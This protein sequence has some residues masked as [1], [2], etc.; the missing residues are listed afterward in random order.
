ML[1]SQELNLVA[2]NKCT[3]DDPYNKSIIY[4]NFILMIFLKILVLDM[5]NLELLK[6]SPYKNK[7][8]LAIPW[9]LL[10]LSPNF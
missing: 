6:I 10:G 5:L 9:L 1:D 8:S 7:Y 4:I 3:T 2:I